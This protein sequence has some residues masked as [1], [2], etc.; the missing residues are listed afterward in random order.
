MI[1]IDAIDVEV[2]GNLVCGGQPRDSE[3]IYWKEVST[4]SNKTN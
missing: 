1:S 2:K 4:R 3:I